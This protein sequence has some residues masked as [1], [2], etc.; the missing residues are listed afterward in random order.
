MSGH[1]RGPSLGR[2]SEAL[3]G[4]ERQVFRSPLR[5]GPEALEEG[6]R[7]FFYRFCRLC[8]VGHASRLTVDRLT[9]DAGDSLNCQL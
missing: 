4:G 7:Q 1:E 6:G 3:G 5:L 2:R 8:G 9:V